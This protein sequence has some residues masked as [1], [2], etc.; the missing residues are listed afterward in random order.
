VSSGIPVSALGDPAVFAV[1]GAKF[2]VY[3]RYRRELP[4][5][6]RSAMLSFLPLVLIYG[7]IYF[8]QPLFDL[9]A[10]G[11]GIVAGMLVP[12]GFP[13]MGMFK[14]EGSTKTAL[15][16]TLLLLFPLA[17]GYLMLGWAALNVNAVRPGEIFR[18]PDDGWEIVLVEGYTAEVY[19]R[20]VLI[21]HPM[22]DEEFAIQYDRKFLR[23]DADESLKTLRDLFGL[24]RGNKE[25]VKEVLTINGVPHAFIKVESPDSTRTTEI[26]TNEEVLRLRPIYFLGNAPTEKAEFMH[27]ALFMMVTS[28]KQ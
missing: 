12:I 3:I 22:R 18:H 8:V 1:I 21:R 15:W 11:V 17:L 19:D 4:P 2:G 24:Y 13:R 6:L 28:F 9:R 7:I 27:E 16:L 23:Q 20:N 14:G 5:P 25:K 26:L 10:V